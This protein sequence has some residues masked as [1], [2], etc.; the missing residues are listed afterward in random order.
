M[1]GLVSTFDPGGLY[2][3]MLIDI[4]TLFNV[5]A[6]ANLTA[7]PKTEDIPATLQR[8]QAEVSGS[9]TDYVVRRRS[10]SIIP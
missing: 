4:V 5:T 3:A 2:S 6:V 1:S 9:A 8:I 10:N 7:Q